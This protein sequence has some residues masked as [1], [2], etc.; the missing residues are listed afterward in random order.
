MG[1]FRGLGSLGFGLMAFLSGSIADR[2]SIRVPFGL[3]AVFAAIAF[4]LALRVREPL[5]APTR[6]QKFTLCDGMAFSR[7]LLSSIWGEVKTTAG[8]F[9]AAVRRKAN[10]RQLPRPGG[11]SFSEGASLSEGT[12]APRPGET[13]RLPLAPLFVS[14]FIWSLVMGAVYAV[15]ANYMVGEIGYSQATMSRLLSIQS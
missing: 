5:S 13:E 8:Q 7:S 4:V 12:S 11:A 9:I 14:A 6:G 10:R 15:W 2:L 1:T 3:A